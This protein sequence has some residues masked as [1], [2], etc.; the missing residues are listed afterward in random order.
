VIVAYSVKCALSADGMYETT[1]GTKA[2]VNWKGL[3]QWHP[4]AS[5]K[6]SCTIDVTFFPLDEQ[7]CYFEFG[8]WT[9]NQKEVRHFDILSKLKLHNKVINCYPLDAMLARVLT[10]VMCLSVCLSVCHT[11]VLYQNC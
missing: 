5:Y 1:E 7:I 4:P 8:S 9:Y 3:V 6:V 10:V 11:P 2:Q